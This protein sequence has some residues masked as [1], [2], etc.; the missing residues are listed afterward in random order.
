MPSPKVFVTRRIP[1]PGL[2]LLQN[3]TQVAIWEQDLPPPQETL[4]EKVRGIEGLVCLL[5]DRVDEEL[6]LAAGS[7]LKVISQMAVGYDNIDIDAATRRGIPVGHTP[8]VLTDATAEFTWALLMAAARRI[9]EADRYTRSGRWK[10]WSPMLLLGG[11]LAGATLGIVGLGRIGRAVARRAQGFNMRIVYYDI[12]RQPEAEAEL[13]IEFRPFGDLLREAD[14]VTIHTWLTEGTYHLFGPD[15]F[16]LMK[17]SAV[18]VNAARGAIVDGK[19]LH[20][21]LKEG[22]IAYAALDVTEPEP[23]DMQNPLLELDN[24]LITPHIASASRST[25]ERMAMMAA[26]NLIAGLTGEPLPN[27]ANPEVYA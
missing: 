19:A 24:L 17:P 6:L 2:D 9:V 27:C 12:Q 5:T 23:I 20:Q 8:G 4:I 26:E 25:R 11:D 10:T 22:E 14:F 13:K 7:S 18:L 15:Q 21:A 16:R 1:Q 3:K